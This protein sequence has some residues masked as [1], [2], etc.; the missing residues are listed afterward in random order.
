MKL[1]CNFK[2]KGSGVACSKGDKAVVTYGSNT[3]TS[4][5]LHLYLLYLIESPSENVVK[6]ERLKPTSV[7][8]LGFL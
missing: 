4:V 8:I 1:Q 7:E 2:M 3:I 6:K 5:G